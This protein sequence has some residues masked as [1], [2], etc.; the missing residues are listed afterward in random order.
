[1]H[2]AAGSQILPPHNAAGSLF[3]SGESSLKTLEDSLGLKR[4]N[5]L[6][7]A[8]LN[9]FR[10]TE[11]RVIQANCAYYMYGIYGILKNIR[12][13]ENT[14]VSDPDPT[15]VSTTKLTGTENVMAYACCLAPGGPTDKQ[16]QVKIFVISTISKVH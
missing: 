2:Y 3:G 16:Q 13:S 8:E 4:D 1:M 6:K 11:F 14:V 15:L 7:V 9:E 10:N 5:H 12:N